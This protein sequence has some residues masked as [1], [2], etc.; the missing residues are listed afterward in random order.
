MWKDLAE[1]RVHKAAQGKAKYERDKAA[2]KCPHCGVRDPYPGMVS[3]LECRGRHRRYA[4]LWRAR[5]R[6]MRKQGRDVLRCH[7]R[8]RAKVLCIQCQAS[9]C[10][11]CYD[12][13]EGRCVECL[14]REKQ[15]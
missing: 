9:M 14:L 5:Q 11:T 8:K 1:Y 3:C 15:G 6:A 7:C 12:L 4:R 2:G 13:G 10:D